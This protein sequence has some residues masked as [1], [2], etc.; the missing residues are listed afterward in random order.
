MIIEV[1]QFVNSPVASQEE[2]WLAILT[3]AGFVDISIET[4][5]FGGKLITAPKA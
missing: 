1:D 5:L 3:V 2:Q 4:H